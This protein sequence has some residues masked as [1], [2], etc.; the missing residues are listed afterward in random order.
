MVI[1]FGIKKCVVWFEIAAFKASIQNTQNGPSTQLV[2]ATNCLKRSNAT[3]GAED[4]SN[5]SIYQMLT[6]D[7][8]W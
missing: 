5:F 2:E 7:K 8:N 1:N 4:L 3:I 6:T